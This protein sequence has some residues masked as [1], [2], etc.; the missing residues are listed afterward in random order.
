MRKKG[1][2][3]FD[4]MCAIV[5]QELSWSREMKLML[6]TLGASLLQVLSQ[7]SFEVN[8]G[9][10]GGPKPNLST[11]AINPLRSQKKLSQDG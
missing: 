3:N 8:C 2:L 1:K 9:Y 6:F 4:W 7:F 11:R 10:L 5:Y